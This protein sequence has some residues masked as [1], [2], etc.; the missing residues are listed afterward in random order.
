MTAASS[1]EPLTRADDTLLAQHEARAAATRL[2]GRLS[3]LGPL[4]ARSG[5]T[6]GSGPRHPQPRTATP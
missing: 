3:L 6:A 5:V 4:G 2:D 1:P